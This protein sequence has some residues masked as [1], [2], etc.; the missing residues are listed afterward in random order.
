MIKETILQFRT[1]YAGYTSTAIRTLI[2][3]SAEFRTRLESLY[4]EAFHKRMN[5]K[6]TSCWLDAFVVLMRYDIN[7]IASMASR[8]FELK[9]GALLIDVVKGDNDLMASHHNLTDE[10]ALYHLRTNPKCIRLFAKYPDNWEALANKE[11]VAEEESNEAIVI[12]GEDAPYEPKRKRA[13][14]IEE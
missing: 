6:C 8:Q 12:N 14:K 9:A 7:K 3:E 5:Q 13:R 11:G 2:K 1:E 10:L 4:Y